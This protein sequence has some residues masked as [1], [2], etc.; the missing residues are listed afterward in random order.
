MK[1]YYNEIDQW[2]SDHQGQL[3]DGLRRLV[4]V[5]SVRGEAEQGT[6]FGPGPRQALEEAKKLAEE[7]GFIASSYDNRL[8]VIPLAEDQEDIL[9]ILAHMDVVAPG[10]GWDTDP[11][12]LEEK[13][14]LLYGRGVDD[15]KG[16]AVAALLAMQCARELGLP[17]RSNV[18]L[19]LGSNEETDMDEDVGYYYAREPYAPYTLSPDASFPIINIEKGHYA[20]SLRKSW[21]ASAALPRVTS[22]S[23]GIRV[24][25][26]PGNASAV[27]MGLS[28]EEIQA[29]A[30]EISTPGVSFTLTEE[31]EEIRIRATGKAAHASTP[32]EGANAITALLTLLA[33]LPLADCSSTAALRELA[34]YFPYGDNGGA[35]LGI[36]Q[37]DHS[38][39]LT[40]T[41]SLLALD[42]TSAKARFDSRVPICA[43][44]G[45]C[46]DLVRGALEPLGWTLKGEMQPAHEVPE[47][48]PFIRTLLASYEEFT[49]EK[50]ECVA[51]G[52][53]TYVHG[54]PGGVAYGA[55]MP[56]YDTGLHGP[57]EHIPLKYLITMGKIY[58]RVILELCG[59]GESPGKADKV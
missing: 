23:G 57:N 22:L 30:D 49:G 5:P 38:G 42:E 18:R 10:E 41:L 7:W 26:A 36:S 34:K 52:G 17:L 28:M 1:A 20:P 31:G 46:S 51:I 8:M 14:G 21:T 11:Y 43:T 59:E 6:P 19:L 53:G 15:D 32:E 56:G 12:Q 47:D 39:P 45:N 44:A 55:A 25:V 50:G 13:D 2:F 54:I 35:A 29:A 9:H 4:A 58:A 37:S 48:S 3:V 16:P 33:A 40:L 24:N 27:L